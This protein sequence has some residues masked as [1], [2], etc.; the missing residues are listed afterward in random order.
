MHRTPLFAVAAVLGLAPAVLAQGA[1]ARL[2]I[3]SPLPQRVATSDAVVTGKVTTFEE[4]TVSAA[5]TA[6]ATNKVEYQVAVIKVADDL[7]GAKGLTHVKV[8]VVKPP[9]GRPV[10]RGGVQPARLTVDEEG[11]FFLQKHPTE[12]FYIL[13]NSQSVIPKPNND[14]YD[15]ELERVKECARLLTDPKAGL[16][17]KKPEERALTAS[18]L[19]VRYNTPRAGETKRE[20]VSAEQSKQ[21]LDALAEADWN[22][23]PDASTPA[24]FNLSPQT[25]FGRLGLTD[26]DGWNAR[27]PFTAPNAYEDAAKAWLKSH[28]DSYRLQRYVSDK[29]D[30]KN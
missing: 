23:K 24:V 9:E 27:G 13:P 6:G 2:V 15:K 17:S 22:P 18:M 7:L 30:E 25:A 3:F 29:K 12:S 11:L 14:N 21:V 5:P 10:I 16:T 26:K 8:G 1:T 28:A 4:K 19:V 20:E